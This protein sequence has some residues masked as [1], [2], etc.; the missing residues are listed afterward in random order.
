MSFRWDQTAPRKGA[1]VTAAF[2]VAAVPVT[3]A[4][5][6][7][8]GVVIVRSEGQGTE[9][10]VGWAIRDVHAEGAGVVD[11]VRVFGGLDESVV[12][13]LE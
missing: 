4:G 1:R 3:A 13:S 8:V 12:V 2:E 9:D 7:F 11:P 10:A 6:D 5:V